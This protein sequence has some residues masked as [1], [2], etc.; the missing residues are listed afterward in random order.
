MAPGGSRLASGVRRL[1]RQPIQRTRGGEVYSQPRA[2]PPEDFLSR[3]IHCFP[4]GA[5]DRLRRAVYLGVASAAPA[6]AEGGG[7]LAPTAR[8]GLFSNGPPGLKST[9]P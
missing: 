1:Q 7:C 4:E 5:R 3:R 6:G 8:R 9:K 2:A